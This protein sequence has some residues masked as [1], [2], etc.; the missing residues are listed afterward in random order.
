VN[1]LFTNSEIANIE[2]KRSQVFYCILRIKVNRM[3]ILTKI[4]SFIRPFTTQS[5]SN[6]KSLPSYDERKKLQKQMGLHCQP[7]KMPSGNFS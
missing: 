3:F 2:K 7:Q 4:E 1:P 5:Y 6:E